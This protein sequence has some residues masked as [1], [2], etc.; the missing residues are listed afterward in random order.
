MPHS[1][2]PITRLLCHSHPGCLEKSDEVR[3]A[4]SHFAQGTEGQLCAAPQVFLSLSGSPYKVKSQHRYEDLEL[5]HCALIARVLVAGGSRVVLGRRR[6]PVPDTANSRQLHN[7]QVLLQ[8]HALVVAWT[9][10]I[11]RP[12]PLSRAGESIQRSLLQ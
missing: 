7:R 3:K 1:L 6:C 5:V 11:G 2:P 12:G 8:A 10:T 9:I 4:P